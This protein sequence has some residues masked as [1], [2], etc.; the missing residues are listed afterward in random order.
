MA[1]KYIKENLI[2]RCHVTHFMFLLLHKKAIDNIILPC[3]IIVVRVWS[4][5]INKNFK[6]V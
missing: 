6:T 4:F 2:C 3:L 5:N 1:I